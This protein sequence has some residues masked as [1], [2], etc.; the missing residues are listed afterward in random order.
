MFLRIIVAYLPRNFISFE[1]KN[2][3]SNS[4]WIVITC[5]TALENYEIH[6]EDCQKEKEKK[7]HKRLIFVS[8][9]IEK[10]MS[11]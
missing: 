8:F 11:G 2:Y 1:K 7:P 5:H 6:E 10:P 4:K 9:C 3:E